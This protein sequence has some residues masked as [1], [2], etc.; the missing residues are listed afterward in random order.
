MSLFEW[1]LTAG[2][3]GLLLASA[4]AS[5]DPSGKKINPQEVIKVQQYCSSIGLVSKVSAYYIHCYA[6]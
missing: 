3:V 1:V 6:Q 2:I 5:S 4:L